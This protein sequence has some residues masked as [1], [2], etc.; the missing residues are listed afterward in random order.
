MIFHSLI[1][2]RFAVV[3]AEQTSIVLKDLCTSHCF[4]NKGTVEIEESTNEIKV[5]LF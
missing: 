5:S 3:V 2:R 4:N 1:F